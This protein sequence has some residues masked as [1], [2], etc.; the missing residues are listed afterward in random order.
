M[1]PQRFGALVPHGGRRALHR[2]DPDAAPG[3]SGSVPRF[4]ACP[5]TDSKELLASEVVPRFERG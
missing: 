4:P 1:P 3:A 5:E 2:V